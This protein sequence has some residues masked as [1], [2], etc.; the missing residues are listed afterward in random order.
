MRKQD[1]MSIAQERFALQEKVTVAEIYKE[2]RSK[3]KASP[4]ILKECTKIRRILTDA[5]WKFKYSA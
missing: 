2:M 3:Q 1:V 5:G 4:D